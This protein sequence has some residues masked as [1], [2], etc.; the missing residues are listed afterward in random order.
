MDPGSYDIALNVISDIG[1]SSELIKEV[2]VYDLP[3]SRFKVN[4][5]LVLKCFFATLSLSSELEKS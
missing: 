4:Y 3:I 5:C 2:V 1:C